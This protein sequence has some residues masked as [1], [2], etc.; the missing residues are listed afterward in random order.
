MSEILE[1]LKGVMP[2][3]PD[4]FGFG[5]STSFNNNKLLIGSLKDFVH[6]I[7]Y[8]RWYSI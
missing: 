1:M 2:K 3:G 7:E 4:K 5:I 8:K 6:L